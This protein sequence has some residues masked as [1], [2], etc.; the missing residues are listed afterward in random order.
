MIF[1]FS[2]NALLYKAHFVVE[3]GHADRSIAFLSA[4]SDTAVASQVSDSNHQHSDGEDEH[5]EGES[6]G[7]DSHSHSSI[8]NQSISYSYT[9]NLSSYNTSEPF[10]FIPEVYLDKF[11]PPQNLA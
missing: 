2:A 4:E 1:L 3:F 7:V 9:P 6:Q 10:R 8:F 11:I 5:H